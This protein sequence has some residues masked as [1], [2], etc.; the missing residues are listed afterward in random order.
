VLFRDS[1][2]RAGLLYRFCSHRAWDL[3]AGYPEDEGLRCAAH[4]WLYN[5]EG[6][7]LEMPLE[8]PENDFSAEIKHRAYP[9]EERGGLIL[10]YLGPNEPP[11]IPDYEFLLVLEEQ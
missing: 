4:G 8:P 5:R 3:A 1:I 2:G 6:Q 10:A 9:V 7:C 11:L